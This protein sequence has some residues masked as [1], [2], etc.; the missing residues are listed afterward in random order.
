MIAFEVLEPP[1]PDTHVEHLLELWAIVALALIILL[2]ALALLVVWRR[3]R[4][5]PDVIEEEPP[6]AG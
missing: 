3:R 1:K 2:V 4:R 5:E 6:N